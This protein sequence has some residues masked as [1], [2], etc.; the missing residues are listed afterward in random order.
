[1]H[2]RLLPYN[3]GGLKASVLTILGI[4]FPSHLSAVRETATWKCDRTELPK[5]VYKISAI[6]SRLILITRTSVVSRGAPFT[7]G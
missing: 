7:R 3:I 1:M 4:C 6:S 2:L 5:H